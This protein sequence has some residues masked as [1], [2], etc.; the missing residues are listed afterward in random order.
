MKNLLLCSTVALVAVGTSQR[1]QSASLAINDSVSVT[2]NGLVAG[3]ANTGAPTNAAAFS[4]S[5]RERQ[6]PGQ[7]AIRVVQLLLISTP[8]R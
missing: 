2:A 6:N 5:A 4:Y 7:V 1:A 3:A 8:V